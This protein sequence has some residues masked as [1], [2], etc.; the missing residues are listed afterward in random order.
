[1]SYVYTYLAGAATVGLVWVYFHR[2]GIW[3]KAKA[4][5]AAAIAKVEEV[6]YKAKARL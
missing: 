5:E 6:I 2:Q 3:A 1:M 4:G